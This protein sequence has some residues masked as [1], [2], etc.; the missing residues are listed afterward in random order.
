MNNLTSEER[1]LVELFRTLT[2]EAQQIVMDTLR[3]VHAAEA[4]LDDF[5]RN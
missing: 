4:A 1:K 2:P 3:L 5:S